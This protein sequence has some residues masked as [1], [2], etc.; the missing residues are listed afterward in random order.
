MAVRREGRLFSFHLKTM[1]LSFDLSHIVSPRARSGWRRGAGGRYVACTWF[2][3]IMM[4]S[5]EKFWWGFAC[6]F[7]MVPLLV[8]FPSMFAW[9]WTPTSRPRR[10]AQSSVS[11]FSKTL[12]G[13]EGCAVVVVCFC[14]KDSIDNGAGESAMCR[15]SMLIPAAYIRIDVI[16]SHEQHCGQNV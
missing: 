15:K 2:S 14:F 6:D 7:S 10:P 4:R 13:Q 11:C 3:L 9:F 1:Y 5:G 16:T 8:S 12:G